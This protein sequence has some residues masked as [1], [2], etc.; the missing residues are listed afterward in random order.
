MCLQNKW[1]L[2]KNFRSYCVK[3]RIV[4]KLI[5]KNKWDVIAKKFWKTNK[6]DL[7]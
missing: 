1:D 3:N 5:L 6:G 2:I 4:L 7:P